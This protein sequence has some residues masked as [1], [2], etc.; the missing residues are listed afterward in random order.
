[1]K[2]IMFNNEAQSGGIDVSHIVDWTLNYMNLSLSA[3]I[4]RY[5]NIF[6]CVLV[7]TEADIKE[8]SFIR[9]Y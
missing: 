4:N 8:K 2:Q 1:M 9:R 6:V 7:R 5:L 3:I